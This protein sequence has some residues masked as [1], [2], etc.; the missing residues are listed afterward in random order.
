MANSIYYAFLNGILGAHTTRV[1]MGV[2]AGGDSIRLALID[3]GAAD[4]ACDETVD[5]FWDDQSAGLIGTAYILVN[6]TRG[7]VAAGVFDNTVDPAPAFTA[8][9]GATVEALVLY[10]HTGTETDSNLICY[11]DTGTGLPLTPNGG[12]VNVTFNASGIFKI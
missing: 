3:E 2:T 4:G 8:V 12:D 11:W 5:D 7:S 9:T 6:K 1:D 10:K